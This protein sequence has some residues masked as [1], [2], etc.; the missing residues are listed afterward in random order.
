[1]KNRSRT[2]IVGN[3]LDAVNGGVT[4]TKIMYIAF[5]KFWA[6]KRIPFCFN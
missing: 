1:M 6:I 3:I 2:E 5:S 4:K